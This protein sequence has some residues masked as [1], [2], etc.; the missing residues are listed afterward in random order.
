MQTRVNRELTESDKR[1]MGILSDVD[2]CLEVV[3]KDCIWMIREKK[4]YITRYARISKDSIDLYSDEGNY[5]ITGISSYS[6]S[7]QIKTMATA[8]YKETFKGTHNYK[9]V[10]SNGTQ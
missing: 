6:T 3:Y 2:Y 9:K 8:K 7:T 4:N 1:I 5:F 10:G